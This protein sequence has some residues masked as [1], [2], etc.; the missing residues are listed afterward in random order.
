MEW[1]PTHTTPASGLSMWDQPE[2]SSEPSHRLD[3]WLEVELTERRGGWARVVFENGFAGWVEAS[4]LVP[5]MPPVSDGL[6][7][8][9]LPPSDGR[10][11]WGWI[12]AGVVAALA[13]AGTVVLLDSSDDDGERVTSASTGPETTA[14]GSSESTAAER[15]SAP[16]TTVEQPATSVATTVPDTVSPTVGSTPVTTA[17]AG[18]PSSVA[19]AG[20]PFIALHVP[21]GWTLSADGLVAGENPA[22]LTTDQPTGL[23]VR[24]VV[25]VIDDPG[26]DAAM[27]A[28]L[29]E[30]SDGAASDVSAA[31]QRTVDGVEAVAITIRTSTR[32]Q[33]LMVVD[34][35][36]PD[37]V[38]FVLDSPAER[39]DAVRDILLSIPGL[40]V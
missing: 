5:A 13:I 24:A 17:A 29:T 31:E 34:P 36:G 20:A 32:V 8:P 6:P 30:S 11:T 18:P 38:L 3:P 1:R 12:T 10:R 27:D 2:P 37:D 40:A 14:A 15:T 35:A 7:P 21:A 9:S 23:V 22:D 25:A 33:V 4:E 28:A 26:F 39:F 19:A 16:A